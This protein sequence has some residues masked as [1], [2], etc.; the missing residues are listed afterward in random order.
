MTKKT[1]NKY[2]TAAA[3]GMLKLYNVSTRKAYCRE[4][5]ASEQRISVKPKRY[6]KI[7]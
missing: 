3:M 5:S 4:T 6:G 7:T 1:T 2:K